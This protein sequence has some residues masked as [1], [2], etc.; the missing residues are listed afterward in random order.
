MNCP[1]CGK[2]TPDGALECASCGLSFDPDVTGAGLPAARP[3]AAA[4]DPDATRLGIERPAP[5]APDPDVTRPGGSPVSFQDAETR[6]GGEAPAEPRSAGRAGDSATD[7]VGQ[8]L[9]TRYHILTLL[10]AGGMGAVYE[11]YDRDLGVVVALKTV[12]PELAADP[13]TARMLERRFKQELLLARQITHKNIVRVHDM[14]EVNG[15]KYITMPFLK[16]EDLATV[17]KREARLPV[18]RV[19]AI[20]RQVASGLAAAHE[21]GVVHRDLKPANIMIDPSGDALIMDFGVATSG[22]QSLAASDRD[23]KIGFSATAATMAGSVVGTIEYM[24]PEQA[25][26]E[27]VDQRA[28]IYAFGLILYDLLLGRT[29]ASRTAS[30]IA[31][32]N[33]RMAEPPP[34]PRTIDPTIPEA[35]DRIIERCIQPAAE[36][37]YPTTAALIADLD[38][39][40]ENGEPLPI[41]RR[42]TWRMAAAASV[43]LLSMVGLT[44]WLAYS[45]APPVEPPPVTVLIADIRNTTGEPELD[46]T[47]EPMLQL[48]LEAASF[49]SAYDRSGIR[50]SLGFRPPD[51]LDERTATELAVKQGLGVVLSGSVAKQGTRYAVSVKATQAVTGK[52]LVDETERAS[53]RDQVLAAATS[54]ATAVREALGEEDS[55]GTAQRFAQET[56]S[57]K[58]LEAVRAYAQG[59]EAL[60][61]SRFD[62]ALKSFRMAVQ[63]DPDFGSAYG[64]MAIV[65]RNLDR[66]QEAEE[67]VKQALSHVDSMTYRERFRTRGM[68]YYLTS[69]YVSCVKEYGDLVAQ[70]SGDASARNN[71]ALCLT[72]LRDFDQAIAEMERVIRILPNRALYRQNLALYKAYSGDFEGAKA[73]VEEMPEKGWL[74]LLAVAF[75][76]TGLGQTQRA[77][78]T[79]RDVGKADEQLGASY[80]A[81]GLADLAIYEGRFTDAAGF[82]AEGAAADLKSDDPYRAARKFASLAYAQLQRQQ[83]AAAI[84]T[85]EKAIATDQAVAVRFLAARIFAEAGAAGRAKAL[86]DGL[87]KEIQAEPRAYGLIVEGLLAMQRGNAAQ[88][89]QNLTDANTLLDTWI[90]HFDLG[91]AYF[92][93]GQF[94]QADSEFERSLN[95]RGEAL[96]LFLDEEPSYGYLPPVYYYQGRVREGLKSTRSAESFGTYLEIRG[97]SPDDPL[98]RDVRARLGR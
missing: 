16:G 66:Q 8:P 9:G 35:L 34:P 89:I 53:N 28:D 77:A 13:E 85:A 2:L 61:R 49:V 87:A 23:G 70:F 76:E 78:S 43:V 7:L 58:S 72:N 25:R 86:A 19:V 94:I 17:L 47:L 45:P 4:F 73:L 15:I 24:A 20:A 52:V 90:G 33:Q 36:N 60:S 38:A 41:M 3:A 44:W 93:A 74:G 65:S 5:P 67:Y 96:S 12:R 14:G 80:T 21:A 46:G 95:R 63:L 31:E 37:R 29:R 56:I 68:Y 62:D 10:G 40:D 50:R 92:Q 91:R 81:S 79:Y 84:A 22:P 83:N 55:S 1:R 32:L 30:V 27:P 11:T 98:V 69:D 51:T 39:L 97:Q 42:W 6:A 54:L 57:T 75:A 59:M 88:A 48:A 26:A 18:R 71:R 64:A 82:L